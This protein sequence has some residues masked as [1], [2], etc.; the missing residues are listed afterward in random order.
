MEAVRPQKTEEREDRAPADE[1]MMASLVEQ[2]PDI[3][4]LERSDKFHKIAKEDFE[5]FL[6]YLQGESSMYSS[7]VYVGQTSKP[8]VGGKGMSSKLYDMD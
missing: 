5:D 8:T 3:E 2:V 7:F 4:D 6:K 1:G